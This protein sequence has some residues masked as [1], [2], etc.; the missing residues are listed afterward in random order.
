MIRHNLHRMIAAIAV[1]AFLALPV[2]LRA[3]S[4]TSPTQKPSSSPTTEKKATPTRKPPVPPPLQLEPKA[5]EILKAAGSR[6]ASAHTLSF[7]AVETFESLSRQGAPLVYANRSEVA[8]A[9]PDKLRVILAGDGPVSEF[10]DDGK[11]MMAYAPVENLVA[12]DDAPPTIDA[13]LEKIYQSAGM[14]FPFTDLIVADPYG[15]LAPGLK[16]AY[17]IGQSKLVGGTTTDMVAY[18]G[19]GVFVQMWVGTE[20]HLPRAMHAI[21]LDDPNLLRHNLTLSDWQIDTPIS[22]DAFTSANA[23]G[24]RKM[25][26][27]NPSPEPPLGAKP[28]ASNAPPKK[29]KPAA[30]PPKSN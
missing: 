4:G 24:A 7:T 16:H 1:T 6:L 12:I 29:T 11:I 3:Q 15:D 20:D 25:Q 26:F 28:P 23:A 18:M 30:T 10:Y 17:Y 14:Y 22:A 21:F 27:A 9:R 13:T 2:S 5:L 8:L 19:D